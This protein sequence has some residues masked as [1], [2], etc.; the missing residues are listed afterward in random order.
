MKNNSEFNSKG[1]PSRNAKFSV[2]KKILQRR[3]VS[4]SASGGRVE[5]KDVSSKLKLLYDISS[6]SSVFGCLDIVIK[7]T[8]YFRHVRPCLCQSAPEWLR[9]AGF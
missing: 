4:F 2:L 1:N 3:Y 9:L 6:P 5:F 8:C 7:I